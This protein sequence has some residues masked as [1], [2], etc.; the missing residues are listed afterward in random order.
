MIAR[1]YSSYYTHDVLPEGECLKLSKEMLSFY[2][3]IRNKNEALA[4]K[5]RTVVSLGYLL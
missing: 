1:F 3:V 5:K 4:G 2:C